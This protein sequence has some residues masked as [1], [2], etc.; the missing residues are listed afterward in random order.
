MHPINWN[1]FSKLIQFLQL[2]ILF[3]EKYYLLI[4]KRTLTIPFDR[5]SQYFRQVLLHAGLVILKIFINLNMYFFQVMES[6]E[7]KLSGGLSYQ[8]V[9]SVNS[10]H[11][12]HS[13]LSPYFYEDFRLV[14]ENYY[15][16]LWFIRLLLVF[17]AKVL[18]GIF[19][20]DKYF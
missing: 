10:T 9:L 15:Q 20:Q 3:Q 7:Q 8:S 12:G 17:M 19:V 14:V 1:L 2:L 6:K 18:Y 13:F 5:I 11:D 16:I 4:L